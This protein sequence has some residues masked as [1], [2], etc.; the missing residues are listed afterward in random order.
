[1]KGVNLPENYSQ[2]AANVLAQKYLR[3]AGIPKNV[4]QILHLDHPS[5]S[6][7]IS[8]LVVTCRKR[9]DMHVRFPWLL[10]YCDGVYS[11]GKEE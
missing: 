11:V 1:M 9:I 5:T 2:V 7:V 10:S 4:F 6:Q 3:K 8:D